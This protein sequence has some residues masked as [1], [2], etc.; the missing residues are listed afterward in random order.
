MVF[1][2][3][4]VER[5]NGLRLQTSP[6][7]TPVVLEAQCYH[8]QVHVKLPANFAVDEMPESASLSAPFGKFVS[9]Y[10]IENG[11]LLFTEDLDVS[12]ATIPAERYGDVKDFF[13]HVAGAE[14]APLVL[15]KN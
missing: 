13:E 4:I 8:K 11:E 7:T 12:V 9:S 10:K 5:W 15:V 2:P 3:A 14:A 6:R 1:R